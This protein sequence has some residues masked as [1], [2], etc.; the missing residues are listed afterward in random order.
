M[1]GADHRKIP[2]TSHRQTPL[3]KA[4]SMPKERSSQRLVRK[5]LRT[6][7]TKETVVRVPAMKPMR[8]A[9]VMGNSTVYPMLASRSYLRRP[10][11]KNAGD[12]S[13]EFPVQE[14]C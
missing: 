10:P 5:V 3:A 6:C 7:G 14:C 2:Y 9:T 12:V 13:H 11:R 1:M 8:V 4:E